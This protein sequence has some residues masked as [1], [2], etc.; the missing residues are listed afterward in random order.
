MRRTRKEVLCEYALVVAFLCYVRD[1]EGQRARLEARKARLADE[2]A[3]H[4]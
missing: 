3:N 4:G 2:L 1:D